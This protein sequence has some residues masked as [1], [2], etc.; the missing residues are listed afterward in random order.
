MLV[1]QRTRHRPG[2]APKSLSDRSG[3][4]IPILCLLFMPSKAYSPDTQPVPYFVKNTLRAICT[5]HLRTLTIDPI[6]G[7]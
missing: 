1:A 3:G 5:K 6:V 7:R 2:T 4:N